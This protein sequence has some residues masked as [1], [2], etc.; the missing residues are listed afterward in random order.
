MSVAA[1]KEAQMEKTL[2]DHLTK[3]AN[4]WRL[5]EDLKTFRNYGLTFSKFLKIIIAINF[6][7]FH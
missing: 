2:I 6:M 7:T 3:D 1:V 4:Q 5:R